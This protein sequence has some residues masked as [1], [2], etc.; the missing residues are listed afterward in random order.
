[1]SPNNL[2]ENEGKVIEI[3]GTKVA[4]FNDKGTLKACSAI[5]THL[6]CEVEWNN[7]EKTWDCPCHGSRF[8]GDGK[9]LNG[10]AKRGLDPVDDEI[11]EKL[12]EEQK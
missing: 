8:H 7:G 6:G 11:M 1:M 4:L 9:L 5:C 3:S 12:Q 2:P 10:P